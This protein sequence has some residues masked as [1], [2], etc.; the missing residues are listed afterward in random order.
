[1]EVIK[2]ISGFDTC[3]YTDDT[4]DIYLDDLK[5][6]KKDELTRLLGDNGNFDIIPITTIDVHDTEMD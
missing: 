5:D 6:E 2:M 1:M 4:I 3:P